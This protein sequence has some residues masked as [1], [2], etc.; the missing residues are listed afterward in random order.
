MRLVDS[1]VSGCE[2]KTQGLVVEPARGLAVFD[3]GGEGGQS[4]RATGTPTHAVV[5]L[6]GSDDQI[7]GL[8][9]GLAGVGQAQFF[10]YGIAGDGR[11]ITLKVTDQLIQGR[12]VFDLVGRDVPQDGYG[13]VNTAVP[14]QGAQTGQKLVTEVAVFHSQAQL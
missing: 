10:P 2:G 9:P 1:A 5:F 12:L 11:L 3:Q 13:Q 4:G 6:T 8:F 14:E 7:V